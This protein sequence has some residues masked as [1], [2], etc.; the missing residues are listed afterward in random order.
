MV[1][2]SHASPDPDYRSSTISWIGAF[3]TRASNDI[4]CGC[5]CSVSAG[6]TV[7]AEGES[8][9]RAYRWY[10]LTLTVQVSGLLLSQSSPG[11]FCR[12]MHYMM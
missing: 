3:M 11:F 7:L 2:Q 12:N 8:G 9:T 10:T 6:Q 5:V 1:I 4:V